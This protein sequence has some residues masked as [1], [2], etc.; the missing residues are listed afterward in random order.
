MYEGSLRILEGLL[1][2]GHPHILSVQQNLGLTLIN[3]GEWERAEPLARAVLEARRRASAPDSLAIG[4]ALE[5]WSILQANLGRMVEA[6]AGFREALGIFRRVVA[7]NHWRIENALRNILGAEAAQGR[8]DNALALLD[9]ADQLSRANGTFSPGAAARQRALLLL[10]IGRTDEALQ[11]SLESERAAAALP[12]AHPDRV[13]AA[14]LRG[15]T[16]YALGDA[17]GAEA[18]FRSALTALESQ[19]PASHPRLG[20]AQ[21]GLGVSLLALGKRDEATPL[22]RRGCPLHERWG[23]AQPSLVAW[24]RAALQAIER[25]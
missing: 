14:L 9:S 24:G 11:A 2:A 4:G 25:R 15:F 17:A 16:A 22:L 13:D 7:P 1:P 21:C 23:L 20:G 19:L 8:V 6:E 5:N 3:L 12:E 10:R 18:R